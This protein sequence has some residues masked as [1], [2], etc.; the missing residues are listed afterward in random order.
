V[1]SEPGIGLSFSNYDDYWYL[2]Q[3]IQRLPPGSD[4]HELLGLI[5]PRPF[6][7]IAGESADSD[8]SWAYI[9]AARP[10]Y[11]LF[12]APQNIGLFN[13]RS[14]HT[15]TPEAVEKAMAWLVHFLTTRFGQ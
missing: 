12:G 7:L 14:G 4:H 1:S 10:V 13:H 8:K 2:G 11:A 3:A 9:N 15:P 6:L 5:A